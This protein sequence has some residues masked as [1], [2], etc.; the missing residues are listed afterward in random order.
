MEIPT[1]DIDERD[2]GPGADLAG[3]ALDDAVL[4]GA[5]LSDARLA[6]AAAALAGRLSDENPFVRGRA[7]EALGLLARAE[8]DGALPESTLEAL[9]ADDDSFVADRALF[10][11]DARADPCE[12]RRRPEEVGNLDGVRA[13]TAE[14][15]EAIGAPDGD[16]ACPHCGLAL[17]AHGPPMCPGCGAPR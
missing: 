5:T 10:A 16:E 9:A 13:T 1:D 8:G 12:D 17:P 7:A 14:A 15:A 11:L 4:A 6:D 3:A 2:I